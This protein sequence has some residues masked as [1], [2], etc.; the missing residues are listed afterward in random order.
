M[1]SFDLEAEAGVPAGHGLHLLSE[2]S[3][4]EGTQP[5]VTHYNAG[6]TKAKSRKDVQEGLH[7]S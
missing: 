6:M 2:Y 4:E 3:S 1:S 5:K 7:I